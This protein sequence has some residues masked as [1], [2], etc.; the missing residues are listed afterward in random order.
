MAKK[1]FWGRLTSKCETAE[2]IQAQG[3]AENRSLKAVVSRI[4]AGESLTDYSKDEFSGLGI[5]EFAGVVPTS[6]RLPPDGMEA[7]K[8][9]KWW[10]FK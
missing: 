2:I 7:T 4:E 1:G 6:D 5:D 9:G 8:V 10:Q 3:N